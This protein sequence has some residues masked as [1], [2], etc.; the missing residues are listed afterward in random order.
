VKVLP[1]IYTFSQRGYGLGWAII[2]LE[3]NK[4]QKEVFY[5]SLS[6]LDFF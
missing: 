1:F 6:V 2:F 4:K 5:S 3:R